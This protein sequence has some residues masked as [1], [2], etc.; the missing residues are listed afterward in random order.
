MTLVAFGQLLATGLAGALGALS[1]YV[2]GRFIAERVTTAFPLGTLVINLTGAFA[3]GLVFGLTTEH[4]LHA[5]LQSV[6]AT[7]FL[8][9]YTTFSTMSWEGV[10]LLRGGSSWLGLLYLIGS[11]LLGLLAAALGLALGRWL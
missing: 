9:G 3:I 4:V 5:A 2:L 10:E 6:L 8:G 1:R 11:A 7:G